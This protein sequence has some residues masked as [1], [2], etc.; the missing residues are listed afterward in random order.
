M[1][2]RDLLEAMCASRYDEAFGI[3]TQLQPMLALDVY[4]SA[5]LPDLQ[6]LIRKR[7]LQQHMQ[8]RVS[9]LH[10]K[11]VWFLQ[12]TVV[13][14]SKLHLHA[15]WSVIRFARPTLLWVARQA[16]RALRLAIACCPDMRLRKR[17]VM[18]AA[19]SLAAHGRHGGGVWHHGRR[20][21]A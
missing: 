15:A 7:A 11:L 2:A 12:S 14:D 3:L 18:H 5:A 13:F 21:A 6:A 10:I 17:G 9:S 16:A 4:A 20:A 1:Q 8:A 19:I